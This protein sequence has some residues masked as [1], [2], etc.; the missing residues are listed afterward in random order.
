MKLLY[1]IYFVSA[2]NTRILPIR[3]NV[4]DPLGAGFLLLL[5]SGREMSADRNPTT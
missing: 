1:W 4:N 3:D 5:L 2:A